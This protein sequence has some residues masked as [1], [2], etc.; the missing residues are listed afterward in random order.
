VYD[1]IYRPAET[2]LLR[3]ASEAGASVA[4]GLS[5]LLHQGVKAFELWTGQ[6]AP[7]AVMRR[8]LRAVAGG[9]KS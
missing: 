9:T 8:A 2:E 4:N 3:V 5:M 1:T 6:T 7:V